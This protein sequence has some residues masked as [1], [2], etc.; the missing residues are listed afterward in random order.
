MK[1]KT[2]EELDTKIENIVKRTVKHY[3]SD[4]KDYDRP[5]YMGLKGSEDQDDKHLILLV[6]PCGT[7][8]LRQCDVDNKVEWAKSVFDYYHTADKS[9]YYYIDLEALTI[10]TE[11][12]VEKCKEKKRASIK[13]R[14]AKQVKPSMQIAI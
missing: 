8:L 2:I 11:K 7:W 9:D 3:Y 10:M 5:K 4:W 14:L 1:Y 12:E 6:R 13:K